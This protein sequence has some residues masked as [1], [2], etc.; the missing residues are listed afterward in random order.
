[1]GSR[2]AMA[3]DGLAEQGSDGELE[4]PC[5][6]VRPIRFGFNAKTRRGNGAKVGYKI[7]SV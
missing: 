6:I 5:E 2:S 3:A 7:P 1:M 4:N